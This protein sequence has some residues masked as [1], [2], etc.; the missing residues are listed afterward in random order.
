MWRSSTHDS[1]VVPI[2]AQRLERSER[3]GTVCRQA[4]LAVDA[5]PVTKA[6]RLGRITPHFDESPSSVRRYATRQPHRVQSLLARQTLQLASRTNWNQA[7]ANHM[8]GK[9]TG[10]IQRQ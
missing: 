9:R 2:V 10:N 5:T 1:P 4:I 8:R 6:S 7:R 3:G